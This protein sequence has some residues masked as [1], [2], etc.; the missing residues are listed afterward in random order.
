M[1]VIFSAE[2]G[3]ILISGAY[4]GGGS[5]LS[6]KVTEFSVENGTRDVDQA[7]GFG[8][9]N[10]YHVYQ[11]PQD[12]YEINLTVICEDAYLSQALMGGSVV[13]DYRVTLSGG[14]PRY[15]VDLLFKFQNSTGSPIRAIAAKVKDAYCTDDS[16]SISS[17]GYLEES[18]KFKCVPTNF[19]KQSTP[20]VDVSG[21]TLTL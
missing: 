19:F 7:V 11:K 2:D 20:N 6:Y 18:F 14:Q 8:R 4:L 15:P 1:S 16:W 12:M 3:E 9:N 17:D 13:S 21:I 5:V 10:R